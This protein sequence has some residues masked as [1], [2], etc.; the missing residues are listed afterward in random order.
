MAANLVFDQVCSEVFDKFDLVA[1]RF[2]AGSLVHARPR[3]ME[4][5]KKPF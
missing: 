3:Q 4:C 5:R 2:A 1:N